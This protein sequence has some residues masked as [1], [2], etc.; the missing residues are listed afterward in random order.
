MRRAGAAGLLSL[1]A[2]LRTCKKLAVE[3]QYAQLLLIISD[4]RQ[5]P[6]TVTPLKGAHRSL[7]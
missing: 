5:A 3:I 6:H 4:R 7:G 2:K 1:Y